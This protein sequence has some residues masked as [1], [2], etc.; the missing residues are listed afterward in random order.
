MRT[1]VYRHE[2]TCLS[3]CPHIRI[4]VQQGH[5]GDAAML[6]AEASEPDFAVRWLPWAMLQD[7]RQ[8]YRVGNSCAELNGPE[9][10]MRIV[11]HLSVR[12]QHKTV[13]DKEGRDKRAPEE[14]LSKHKNFFGPPL[15][16]AS[17]VFASHNYIDQQAQTI[18]RPRYGHN[19]V[20]SY[21]PYSYGVY[22]Y[23]VHSYGLCSHG[24]YGYDLYNYGL[25]REAQ[26]Q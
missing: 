24:L 9:R 15:S 10:A 7:H 3:I 1:Y 8:Y 6:V 21:G 4:R 20:T 13:A 5:F 18:S 2:S 26:E 12:Q 17:L 19:Y 25:G 22:S 14:K 11:K 16:Q 23:G